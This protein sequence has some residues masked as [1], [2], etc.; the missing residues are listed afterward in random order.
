MTRASSAAT[1]HFR[2]LPSFLRPISGPD[3]FIFSN[4]WP[5]DSVI[6]TGQCSFEVFS[7]G[8]ILS[9]LLSGRCRIAAPPAPGKSSFRWSR[10]TFDGA[11]RA[12]TVTQIRKSHQHAPGPALGMKLAIEPHH[13]GE[14]SFP[15]LAA[16]RSRSVLIELPAV[17][18]CACAA[19]ADGRIS[20]ATMPS[21]PPRAA[22]C[23]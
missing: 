18:G 14:M 2:A 5:A 20:A 4:W 9:V 23:P 1:L 10:G 21:S 15:N 17:L 19:T 22:G 7:M 12:G 16:F 6:R 3:N 11:D 13:F 8:A